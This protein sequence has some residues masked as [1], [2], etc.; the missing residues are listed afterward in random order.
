MHLDPQLAVPFALLAAA[1][2]H[3]EAEPPRRVAA[4]LGLG[5][6]GIQRADQI[7]HAGVG[8]RV[9]GRRDAQ[10]LLIDADHLVDLFDAA[11]RVVR[12]RATCG[13]G[14]ACGPAQLYSTSSTSELLPL[15]LTPVTTVSVPSGMRAVDA[16]QIVVPGADSLPASR[17]R[18]ARPMRSDRCRWACAFRLARRRLR[19]VAGSVAGWRQR[20]AMRRLVGTAIA[21]LPDRYGPV[22]EVF[23]L[24]R[25]RPACRGR[26]SRRPVAG[27]RAE[28]EQ[29]IGAGDHFAIVLDQQQRVAQVAQLFQRLD[30]PAV[31]ARV[32]ADR[33]LVEHIQHAAQAAA[34]LAGQAN[35]LGFAA[36][37]RRGGRDRA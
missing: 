1:A 21:F 11:N 33:R 16:A 6:I 34:D 23:C 2:R 26:R 25:L 27:R 15:P 36:R 7:E 14:A 3:V 19:L 18:A 29:L 13:R 12:R 35:A 30:Q 22:T 37:E 8:G 17:R 20:L 31:V 9:R 10:R 32:Q 5:Q 4:Q 28:V 24:G